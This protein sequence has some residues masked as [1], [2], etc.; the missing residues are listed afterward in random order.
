MTQYKWSNSPLDVRQQ[1]EAFRNGVVDLL[2]DNL[3]GF[4]LHGSLA[5]GCFNPLRS[6]L[7]MLVITREAMSLDVLREAARL[8]LRYSSQPR[9]FEISFVPEFALHPW[10]YPTPYQFHFGENPGSR[11]AISHD[12]ENQTWAWG[13]WGIG[14]N[15]TDPDLAAH[16]V[17]TRARGIVL[18]GEPIAEVIPAVPRADYIDSIRRDFD[19]ACEGLAENP[20]YA[21]LNFCRMAGYL[22][23]GRIDSK[24]EAG[25]WAFDHLPPKFNSLIQAALD[26]YRRDGV[27][28][29]DAAALDDFAA[30]IRAQF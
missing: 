15:F 25:V 28:T 29:F 9:P 21:V 5:M 13:G 7:D 20:V 10:H 1:V 17:V 8:V 2:G 3:L 27:N 16:F 26:S 24:D 23:E 4:Y 19:S 11:E 30:Y 12:L 22:A 6:D 18:A 14:E